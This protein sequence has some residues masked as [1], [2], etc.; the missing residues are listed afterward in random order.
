MTPLDVWKQYGAVVETATLASILLNPVVKKLSGDRS[1]IHR[2][3]VFG[4]YLDFC[5]NPDGVRDDL[6]PFGAVEA[7]SVFALVHMAV[8]VFWDEASVAV[9]LR[10]QAETASPG[11]FAAVPPLDKALRVHGIGKHLIKVG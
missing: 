1:E 9:A 6:A 5:S 3:C 10:R 2:R 8:V 11:C 4:R 7:V